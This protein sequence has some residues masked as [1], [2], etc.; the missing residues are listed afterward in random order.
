MVLRDLLAAVW[1]QEQL[2]HLHAK[3]NTAFH[4]EETGAS[5]YPDIDKLH[6]LL[7]KVQ[8]PLG[9]S[10]S[11]DAEAHSEAT[12]NS[13]SPH[14]EGEPLPL[15]LQG[16]T[17][18]IAKTV[19][20]GCLKTAMEVK[21]AVQDERI[22]A[23]EVNL[24]FK[25]A[26]GCGS[27][28]SALLQKLFGGEAPPFTFHGTVA[29]DS[30]PWDTA[31]KACQALVTHSGELSKVTKDQ[32]PRLLA[33]AGHCTRAIGRAFVLMPLRKTAE[34]SCSVSLAAAAT[35]T[36]E[37]AEFTRY[38]CQRWK[39]VRASADFLSVASVACPCR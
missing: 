36:S 12:A 16:D 9:L 37:L 13:S 11:E 20:D 17:G 29:E 3:H 31:N 35:C 10:L 1:D 7:V 33:E 4:G 2:H 24:F 18:G 38:H 19:V 34:A 30:Q 21:K 39:R 14:L 15:D 6:K 25:S 8:T 22:D 5:A 32:A 28:G 23:N 26:G 27:K